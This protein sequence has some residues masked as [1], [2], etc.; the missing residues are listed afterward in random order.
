MGEVFQGHYG[1]RP[2]LARKRRPRT[3]LGMHEIGRDL[4]A[5]KKGEKLSFNIVRT[6]LMAY[7]ITIRHD[8]GEYRVNIKAGREATAYYTNDLK[9]ALDTGI[10]MAKKGAW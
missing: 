10:A 4:V 6:T 7:N 3:S 8:D 1:P 5:E 2:P 9:D